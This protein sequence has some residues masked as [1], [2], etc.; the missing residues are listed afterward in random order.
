MSDY[1]RS[2]QFLILKF[3]DHREEN[4][5]IRP[6]KGEGHDLGDL[7]V[8]WLGCRTC[9]Q[10]VASTTSAHSLLDHLGQLSFPSLQGRQ[11]AYRSVWLKA[12]CVHLC[13]VAG[14]A[15]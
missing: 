12:G 11:I 4:Q 8:Q 15:V 2:A 3:V 5:I 13:L 7:A 9:N 1:L 10:Q 14:K 6:V